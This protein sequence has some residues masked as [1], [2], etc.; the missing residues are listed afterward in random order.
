VTGVDPQHVCPGG[1]GLLFT[2]ALREVRAAD[3]RARRTRRRPLA[4]PGSVLRVPVTRGT[5][6]SEPADK[7]PSG[8]PPGVD[9]DPA[10]RHLCHVTD[11]VLNPDRP[12]GAPAES[13]RAGWWRGGA[14]PGEPGPAVVVGHVDSASG[15][16]VSTGSAACASITLGRKD[17]AIV[18]YRVTGAVSVPKDAFPTR[19][20][21]WPTSG[22]TLRLI[23]CDGRF[24]RSSGHYRDNLVVF[25]TLAR[26]ADAA[27]TRQNTPPSASG[28]GSDDLL[29]D[30]DQEASSGLVV[31]RARRAGQLLEY[32][33]FDSAVSNIGRGPLVLRG[34]RQVRSSGTRL[35]GHP[36]RKGWYRDG[37]GR[38]GHAIRHIAGSLTGTSWAL[39]S[40]SCARPPTAPW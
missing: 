1:L 32:L 20:V 19:A 10:D 18:R 3:R 7:A 29:P 16:A 9:R 31:R 8:K 13:D 21:Y 17:G 35:T 36:S 28:N 14:S 12:L 33:G 34:R 2:A 5:P 30:L 4:T 23:T 15:P 38:G 26:G 27:V 6:S 22:P 11:F 37:A 39:T 40:T 24:D 25:A